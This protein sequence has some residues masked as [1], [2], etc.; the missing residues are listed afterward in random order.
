MSDL[1]T[2]RN[3]GDYTIIVEYNGKEIIKQHFE[4]GGSEINYTHHIKPPT[5]TRDKRIADLERLLKRVRNLYA[6]GKAYHAYSNTNL[7]DEIRKIL[8]S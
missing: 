5:D 8:K 3:E 7:A 2:L 1:I 6:P 4:N